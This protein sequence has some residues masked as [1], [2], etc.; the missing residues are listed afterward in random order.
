MSHLLSLLCASAIC[1]VVGCRCKTCRF[2]FAGSVSCSKKIANAAVQGSIPASSTGFDPHVLPEVWPLAGLVGCVGWPRSS[3]S[4]VVCGASA[5]WLVG[6]AV[7][8]EGRLCEGMF[9][10][11]WAATGASAS[12]SECSELLC[13]VSGLCFVSEVF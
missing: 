8:Q 6:L 5:S 10:G 9:A 3:A 13:R 11:Q 2:L 4:L 7:L 12:P 1:A